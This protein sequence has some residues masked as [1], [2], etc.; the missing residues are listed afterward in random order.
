RPRMPPPLLLVHDDLATIASVRR[1]LTRAGHALHL[2]TSTADALSAFEQLSPSAIL[3][4][5]AVEGGRGPSFLAE[6]RARPAGAQA[7]VVLLGEAVPGASLPVLALPLDAQA[8]L[9]AVEAALAPQETEEDD[10]PLL[11]AGHMEE[12]PPLVD[13]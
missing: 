11:D 8:L 13:A 7:P 6:L 10:V 2:A 9:E 12:L 5:P 4:A 3:L 1:V